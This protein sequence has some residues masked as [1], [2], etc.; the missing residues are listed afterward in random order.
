MTG[1]VISG[2]GARSSDMTTVWPKAKGD[3]SAEHSPR[4]A[5]EDDCPL[6]AEVS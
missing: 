5:A 4:P 6:E 2:I 1:C 3:S